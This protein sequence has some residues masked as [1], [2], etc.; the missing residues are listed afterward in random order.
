[1]EALTIAQLT[2]VAG[3]TTATAL[4]SELFWRT[5]AVS[6]ATKD[7]F[8]PLV[9]VLIGVGAGVVA[10][11]LLGQ[12]RLDLAQTVVNGVMGGLAAM[13][14]HDLFASKAGVEL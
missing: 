6:P 11:A 13:G 9:A 12:N 7:R 4:L 2:T 5:V 1:M 8:G 10:G 3:L 14:V